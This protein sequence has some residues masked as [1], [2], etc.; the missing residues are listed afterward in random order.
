MNTDN[1]D[2]RPLTREDL[3]ICADIAT[4]YLKILELRDCQDDMARYASHMRLL[5][6]SK[7]NEYYVLYDKNTNEVLGWG[8]ICS[9]TF[10]DNVAGGNY[11]YIKMGKPDYYRYLIASMLLKH[12]KTVYIIHINDITLR[13]MVD[14]KYEVMGKHEKG[15]TIYINL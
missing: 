9:I 6:E 14:L 12:N 2:I 10:S 15:I 11:L 3:K 8:N 13:K 1:L 4:P 5:G 7:L